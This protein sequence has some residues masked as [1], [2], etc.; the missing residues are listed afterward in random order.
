MKTTPEF[1]PTQ[2]AESFIRDGFS[3]FEG[4]LK[5]GEVERLRSAVASIP[6]GEEV[7]RKRSVYGIRNLL[8]VCP[9]I[10]SLAAQPR[11]CRLVT[12]ILG[13]SAFAARAIFFGKVSDANWAL[14]WH[15][16]SVISVSERHD[17]AGFSAWSKKAG[18][19][20]VQPPSEILANMVA[21][22]IHLDDCGTDNGPL[23]VIPGSH[24]HGWLDEEIDSWKER[25]HE[26]TCSVARGGV[27][28]ICPLILHASSASEA[29]GHR[30]VIHIEYASDELPGPLEWNNRIG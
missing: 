28:T 10:R 1:H 6:D 19:W 22:R 27:V 4:V 9:A 7:R 23:R 17:I 26:V 3:I 20:Q 5:N 14:G 24:R 16:D 21:V 29:A 13:D 11:I 15:Q 12:P 30:R 18:V 25:G 2:Y 8:E